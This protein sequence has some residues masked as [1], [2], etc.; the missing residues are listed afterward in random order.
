LKEV[1]CKG[2]KDNAAP[3]HEI[4]KVAHNTPS[5]DY[6]QQGVKHKALK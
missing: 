1:A 2:N 6:K 5:K 3:Y 4:I